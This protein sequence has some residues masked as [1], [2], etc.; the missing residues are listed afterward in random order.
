V[1]LEQ[2]SNSYLYFSECAS[3]QQSLMA[4][5]FTNSYSHTNCTNHVYVALLQDVTAVAFSFFVCCD[6][7]SLFSFLIYSQAF[8]V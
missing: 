3:Y 5:V 2:V 1:N 4:S 8:K 7:V 6:K